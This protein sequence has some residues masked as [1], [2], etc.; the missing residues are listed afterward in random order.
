MPIF[1]QALW[2][3]VEEAGRK[4]IRLSKQIALSAHHSCQSLYGTTVKG[5][6]FALGLGFESYLH[7]QC[8]GVSGLVELCIP[9]L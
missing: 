8:G 4:H 1:C 5:K 2:G 9:F 7:Q 6:Q 3:F